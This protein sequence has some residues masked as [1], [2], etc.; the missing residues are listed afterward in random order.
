MPE[1]S[2]DLYTIR[3]TLNRALRLIETATVVIEEERPTMGGIVQTSSEIQKDIKAA[4]LIIDSIGDRVEEIDN[5]RLHLDQILEDVKRAA[6]M[7]A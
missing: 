4:I 7:K 2:D 1:I 6:R 3:V 5:E